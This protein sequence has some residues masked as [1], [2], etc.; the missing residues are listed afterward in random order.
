[1]PKNMKFFVFSDSTLDYLEVRFFKTKVFGSTLVFGLCVVVGILLV[2][3][4]T[5]DPLGIGSDRMAI[6]TEENH[7]L[8]AQLKEF[9]QKLQGLQEGVEV[10]AE[11]GNTLR[12]MVD[13][14]KIDSDTRI[15]AIGGTQQTA[16]FPTLS[17]SAGDL[18]TNSRNMIDQLD[19]EVKLQQ[20][21]YQ[22][23]QKRYEYNKTF[24]ARMPA[25][26]PMA[27]SYVIDG[28]GMRVHP[29]LHVWRMHEGI[30]IIADV[31]TP[32][33]ATADGTVQYVGRTEGGYGTVIEISHGY[34]FVTLY[35][36]LSEVRARTGQSV[37][38]GELIAKSGRSGLVSGPHLHYEVH[39]NGMKQNPVDYFF[40]DVDASHYRLQLASIN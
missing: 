11:R 15:A 22:E 34:G 10:L 16:M 28:F 19:R 32:V 4:F 17:E 25:I 14:K 37:K 38:R 9:S 13:L 1:M 36:H 39:R 21:S 26:K 40:D 31:G 7:E 29:V 24:F 27:G 2:N 12:L 8:K 20:V 35:A 6:L 18:L 5:Q 3:H 23:I 33:Y 30:D